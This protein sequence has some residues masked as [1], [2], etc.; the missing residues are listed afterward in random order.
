MLFEQSVAAA[1]TA[2]PIQLHLQ[3]MCSDDVQGTRLVISISTHV[4]CWFA[5][6][7]VLGQPVPG[8]AG[9]VGS[10][11]CSAMA[12]SNN[13][14]FI[15]D[16]KGVVYTL[17]CNIKNGILQVTALTVMLRCTS[18]HLPRFPLACLYLPV[19]CFI[20]AAAF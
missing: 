12:V 13:L 2:I 14:L 9:S 18:Q 8:S 5:G 17:R 1:D 11:S 19:I 10:I 4:R 3:N 15:A 16:N 6:K 7:L 20:R